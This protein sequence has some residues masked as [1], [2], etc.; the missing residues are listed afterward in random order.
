ML[1]MNRLVNLHQLQID[2]ERWIDW[3]GEMRW[4]PTESADVVTAC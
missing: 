3:A 4:Q 1:Q 2:P